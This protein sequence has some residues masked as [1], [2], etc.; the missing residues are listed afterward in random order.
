MAAV[1]DGSTSYAVFTYQCGS[2]EWGS[3]SGRIGF[4]IGS[5]GFYFREHQL[6]G[7]SNNNDIA[8]LNTNFGYTVIVYKLTDIGMTYWI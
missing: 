7:S 3:S 4:S 2:M 8:C 1:T 5:S 6:S